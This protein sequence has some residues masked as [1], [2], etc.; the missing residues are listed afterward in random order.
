LIEV[1]KPSIPEADGARRG[2][3]ESGA[4]SVR[5]FSGHPL[6]MRRGFHLTVMSAFLAAIASLAVFAS[7]F[8]A[9]SK[10]QPG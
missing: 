3:Q 10:E 9:L 4:T 2:T 5:C 6:S 1:L 8:Y 7:P